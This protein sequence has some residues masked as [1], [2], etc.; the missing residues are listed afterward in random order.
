M[1]GDI[2]Y[3]EAKV[4]VNELLLEMNQK[5]KLIAQKNGVPYKKLTFQY[6]FR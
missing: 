1:L 3:D 2:T 4:L 6:V 5:C